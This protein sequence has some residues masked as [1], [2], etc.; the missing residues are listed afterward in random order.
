LR[1]EQD[2][3]RQQQR[4]GSDADRAKALTGFMGFH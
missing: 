2:S 1:A 3:H 4:G